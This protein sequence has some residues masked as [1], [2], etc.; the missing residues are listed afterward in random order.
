MLPSAN[1]HGGSVLK[2]LSNFEGGNHV[3]LHQRLFLVHGRCFFL[4]VRRWIQRVDERQGNS[5]AVVEMV[6][7][8]DMD[9][10]A[11]IH[12]CLRRDQFG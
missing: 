1:P 9:P 10:V 11:G 8:G 2:I 6:S 4:Y 5:D 7:L 3:I 12:L